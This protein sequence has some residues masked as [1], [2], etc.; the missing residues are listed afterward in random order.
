MRKMLSLLLIPLLL[1]SLVSPAFGSGYRETALAY[2]VKKYDVPEKRIELH[3]GGIMELEF[4]AESFWNGRYI[5]VPEG[6]STSDIPGRERPLP[7]PGPEPMPLP[8]PESKRLPAP[9]MGTSSSPS[10]MP[11]PPQDGLDKG[12]IYDDGFIYGDINIRIKTGEILEHKQMESFFYAEGLLANQEWERLRKEAGKLDVSLYRKLQGLSASE[13]VSVWILPTPVETEEVRKQFAAL[14][15]KYPEHTMGMELGEILFNGY[16]YSYGYD[17]AIPETG[18]GGVSPAEG[19]SGYAGPGGDAA[20][21]YA[22]PN[23]AELKRPL[24]QPDVRILP[25]MPNDEYWQEYNDMWEELKQIRL[26]AAIPSL[27]S[28]KGT[29][30]KMGITHRENAGSVV[31]DLT[32]SQIHDIAKLPAVAAV[33]EEMNFIT[34]DGSMEML[35]RS[36]APSDISAASGET[37]K[38]DSTTSYLPGILIAV[39][40]LAAALVVVYRRRNIRTS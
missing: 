21:S 3:E 18:V 40:V 19:S 31:A 4:T 7:L 16:G 27:A 32:V 1:T 30:D 9:D 39:T 22:V 37:M 24:E 25:I 5:I 34:M 6:K 38:N 36:S 23:P 28:I 10:I 13:K 26:Q 11:M 20:V 8:E 15:E 33:F 29:L 2:L 14:K 35:A 12:Y 17:L